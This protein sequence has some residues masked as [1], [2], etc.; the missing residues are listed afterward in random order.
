MSADTPSVIRV[1]KGASETPTQRLLRKHVPAWVVSG[2]THVLLVAVLL[3]ASILFARPPAPPPSDDQ[4]VV[5]PDDRDREDK[6]ANLTEEIIGLDPDL[7]PAVEADRLDQINV[8]TTV[9]AP[10]PGIETATQTTP[11]DV[12][13]PP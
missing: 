10:D 11:V 6:E 8:E 5:V 7:P 3:T 4:L 9:Q 1:I 12:S 13:P 2:A